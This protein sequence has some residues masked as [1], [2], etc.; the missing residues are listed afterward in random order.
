MAWERTGYDDIRRQTYMDFGVVATTSMYGVQAREF[1]T[2]S[3]V[4]DTALQ[5]SNGHRFYF[6][7][8]RKDPLYPEFVW[9]PL[10][11]A[12]VAS[13]KDQGRPVTA[14]YKIP[15]ALRGFEGYFPDRLRFGLVGHEIGVQETGRT[16]VI[17]GYYGELLRP[18]VRGLMDHGEI[19]ALDWHRTRTWFGDDQLGR[20]QVDPLENEDESEGRGRLSIDRT[21]T[22]LNDDRSALTLVG[23]V[24][25][26]MPVD[27]ERGTPMLPEELNDWQPAVD[28][29]FDRLFC[30]G[31]IDGYYC[32]G[33][34]YAYPDEVPDIPPNS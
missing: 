23:E 33:P 10:V 8:E 34:H 4:F 15:D 12:R 31:K 26:E 20:V 5:R 18:I 2:N 22:Y 28:G 3:D 24:V 9:N 21:Y 30:S 29:L 7:L 13:E 17:T 32:M 14:E 11:E 25:A 6:P 27:I 19:D 1:I 16:Q